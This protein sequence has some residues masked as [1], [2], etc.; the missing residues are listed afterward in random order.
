M[1]YRND[2]NALELY[3]LAL[4]YYF[5]VGLFITVGISI[6]SKEILMLLS[7]RPEYIV[8]YKV[9][10]IVMVAFLIY[11][12]VGIIDNGIYFTRKVSYHAYIFGSCVF[13]NLILNYTLIPSLGYRAAAYNIL[14]TFSVVVGL[15]F[16]ISNKLFKIQLESVRLAKIFISS[17]LVLLT[18]MTLKY[19]TLI[20][21][22]MTKATLMVALII[23]WYI[24]V[25]EDFEK[26]KI[27]S[28]LTWRK[29][30]TWNV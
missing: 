26:E 8:A 13:L 3:K 10:P 17:G 4:T 22:V 6:F 30:Q 2:R 23:F 25:L 18:G 20:I 16:I 14:I 28:L 12:T 24:F 5:V 29:S 15:V 21:A 11:G 7:G 27:L 1:D 9:V 19:G